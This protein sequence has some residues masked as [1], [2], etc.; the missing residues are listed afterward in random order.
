MKAAVWYNKKEIKVEDRE[1]RDILPNEVKV[2]VAWAGIC[3]S[4]LHEYLEGP[5]TI[6]IHTP[7]PLTNQKAPLTMGHEFSGEIEEVGLNV[8]RF[9][10]G[11]RV[12]VNP[13]ITY[14]NKTPKYDVYDG[15]NFIGLG[16]DGGF[17]DFTIVPEKNVYKLPDSV[18]LE[19]GALVEPTAVAVQAIKEANLQ[20]D[21]TVAVIGAGPIGLLTIIAAKA[22]GASKI[23]AFDLSASRLEKAI[24]VGATHIIKSDEQSPVKVCTEIEP[25]GF[26]VVFEVAGAEITLNQAIKIAKVRG[27]VVIVS[28]FPKPVLFNPMDLTV[29]GVKITSS[30]A[31]EPEVFQ[32]TIDLMATGNIDCKE[33]ITGRIE[34]ERIIEDGFNVLSTDKTQAKILVRLSGE[35]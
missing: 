1:I 14:G 16:R 18:S 32:K 6:P 31:Y 3:G 7:D 21:Q 5:I 26:D 13:L 23:V 12:V 4:D 22:A 2:K 9:K 8:T 19:E 33:I 35:N 20:S 17:A 29:S 34:L 30:L 15:F 27:I 24:R 11:D 10:K 28:L 25:N